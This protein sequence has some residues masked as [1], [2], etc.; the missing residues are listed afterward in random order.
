MFYVGPKQGPEG[1]PALSVASLLVMLNVTALE[2][3]QFR[4][5]Q[6]LC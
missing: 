3:V 4:E 5:D 2:S 1:F 6:I